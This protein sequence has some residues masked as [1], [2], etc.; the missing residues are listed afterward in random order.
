[1]TFQDQYKHPNWQ[2]KRLKIMERDGFHCQLCGNP[3]VQL[4][5]HHK[6]YGKGKIWEVDDDDLITV[7]TTC[8]DFIKLVDQKD[9]TGIKTCGVPIGIHEEKDIVFFG[10]YNGRMFIRI[11]D[12]IF[13]DFGK[14]S[15]EWLEML[16]KQYR[17]SGGR[18]D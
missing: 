3:Y 13:A 1:M 8:H 10:F 6:K 14:K 16:I 9:L 4:H 11:N 18:L 2:K 15:K 17:K 12:G 7:C 5:V